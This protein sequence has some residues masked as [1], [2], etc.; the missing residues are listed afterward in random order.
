MKIKHPLSQHS[1]QHSG[2]KKVTPLLLNVSL[3]TGFLLSMLVVA[4]CNRLPET[5]AVSPSASPTPSAVPPSPLASSPSAEVPDAASA[6]TLISA[7]GIG[8]ARLGMTLATLKQ[9]LGDEAEFEVQSPFMVDF[10]AIAVRKSGT[11]QYYILYLADQSFE[12]SDVIQGL[13]TENP[14]FRTAADVGPDTPIQQ[15]ERAYGK[16]TVSYSTSNESREYVR[17]ERQPASNVSF[18]TGTVGDGSVG[19]YPS[20]T[21][22]Y[23]ETQNVKDDATIKSVLVVCLSENC[24]SP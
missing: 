1:S 17:F 11:V 16:A 20:P 22:E 6:P 4:G 21:G 15:A 8:E 3:T 18:G 13:L 24:A 10:D 9:K 5:T 12:D 19:I 14:S 7:D 2:L 23:N